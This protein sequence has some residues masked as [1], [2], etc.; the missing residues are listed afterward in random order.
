MAPS[1]VPHLHPGVRL[2]LRLA[3][4]G[5]REAVADAAAAQHLASLLLPQQRLGALRSNVCRG[6]G[7]GGGGPEVVSEM[8]VRRLKQG[9]MLRSINGSRRRDK[10]KEH[11][12]SE[13]LAVLSG[14]LT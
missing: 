13:G 4:P 2:L 12:G 8:R 1:A 3:W 14:S 11:G 10:P 6:S 9:G 7:G 5:A